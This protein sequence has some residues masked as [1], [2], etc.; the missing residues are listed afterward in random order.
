[1]RLT[2]HLTVLLLAAA[3]GSSAAETDPIT[4]SNL[5]ELS[6][7]A[8]RSGQ[9]VRMAPG[10]YRLIDHISLITIPKRRKQKD[11]QFIT[12]SGSNN[13]FRL[14]GVTLE[15]DTTL[16]AALRPPIHNSEFVVSGDNNVIQGLAITNIGEGTSPGGALLSIT[17]QGN[18]LRDCRFLV[19]GSF[20][21]G[22]GDLF[23]KGGGSV[24]SHRKQS[25]VHI[26]G[27]HTSLFGCRLTMRS[28]GHGYYVQENAAH[29]HFENCHVEGEMRAT[30]EMLA[31]TS[32]PAF[33]VQF[34]TVMKNRA[35]RNRV[36]PGYVKSLA[37]DGFRTYGQH[38]N[39]TFV[40]CTAKNMRGGFELRTKTGVRLEN[41]SAIG[42]ERG[43]WVSSGA[44]V[45]NCRG[46]AQYGPLLFVEGDGVAV[47][48]ELLP[49]GSDATVHAL[50]TIHGAGHKVIITSSQNGNSR[51]P[52]PI[53]VGYSQPSAGEGMSP[54]GERP[55]RDVTLR[56]ETAMPVV[57]GAQATDGTITTLGP[58]LEN[59]GAKITVTD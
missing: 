31:E 30:D 54:I 12:F 1:M 11:F 2:C 37:E 25:G 34:R 14:D 45:V 56:N 50:A 4:V 5:A 28:F 3:A 57:I 18:T 40:N 32:G 59:A 24:I 42:N 39:L 29:V 22:Y 47:D 19:R 43:F 6:L 58:V 15:V 9:T 35:G 21:Y 7:A 10:L 13:V 23:G 55:T 44:V 36:T 46:D 33:D 48:L 53:L 27:D 41:C 49:T 20:P 52:V 16:R 38:K 17:G 51:R 26:T 8:R